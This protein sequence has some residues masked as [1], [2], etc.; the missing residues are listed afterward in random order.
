VS[1]E[2]YSYM[3]ELRTT[4]KFYA[5]NSFIKTTKETIMELCQPFKDAVRVSTNIVETRIL[6]IACSSLSYMTQ[7]SPSCFS[8][9]FS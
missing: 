4:N 8:T 6:S 9:I 2:L 1:Q 5:K 7:N 3:E